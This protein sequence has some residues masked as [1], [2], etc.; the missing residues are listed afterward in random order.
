MFKKLGQF[1]TGAALLLLSF[2][3]HAQWTAGVNYTYVSIDDFDLDAIVGS[4]GYRFPVSDNLYAIPEVRAGFGLG[5]NTRNIDG[6]RVKGEI[7][8][9][10]GFAGRFQYESPDTGFFLFG[11][12][13]Y[14]NYEL[15]ASGEGFS[16][17]DD[18]WEFGFGAGAGYMFTPLVGGEATY[19]R[20][21]GEDV[22][23]VGVRFN[24]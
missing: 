16:V 3:A 15:K 18:S 19:E 13:S 1:G 2:G 21:D 24:F 10:W 23:T 14:V 8:K 12:A 17:S 20:V 11:I 4:L 22:F 7:D 6:L 9:L 5:D